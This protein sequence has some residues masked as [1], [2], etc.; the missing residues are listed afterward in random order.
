MT[1]SNDAILGLMRLN[2]LS[3]RSPVKS[4]VK[5]MFRM[6]SPLGLFEV[7]TTESRARIS[8][9]L[10]FGTDIFAYS[11]YYTSEADLM[12]AKRS[13]LRLGIENLFAMVHAAFGSAQVAPRPS[14]FQYSQARHP[15]IKVSF[16]GTSLFVSSDLE[17]SENISLVGYNF[18]LDPAEIKGAEKVSKAANQMF[19]FLISKEAQIHVE[20]GFK[21]DSHWSWKK[22]RF[23][24]RASESANATA[25]ERGLA[26]RQV[27]TVHQTA[28]VASSSR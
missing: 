14:W 3:V 12:V 21:K 6:K 7:S 23:V 20:C 19:A 26:A 1:R 22:F 15:C 18:Y 27:A 16:E 25:L 28:N 17:G 4:T 11:C 2:F 5:R 8:L 10:T 9:P 24:N 13:D